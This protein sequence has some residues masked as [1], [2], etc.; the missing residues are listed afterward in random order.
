MDRATKRINDFKAF[1]MRLNSEGQLNFWKKNAAQLAF[2]GNGDQMRFL[3]QA[4]EKLSEINKASVM[5]RM[6]KAV[7]PV[8]KREMLLILRRQTDELSKAAFLRGSLRKIKKTA[9]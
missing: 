4:Q 7:D 3:Y 9:Y 8:A 6:S 5:V 2:Y 1:E